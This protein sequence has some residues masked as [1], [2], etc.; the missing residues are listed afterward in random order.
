MSLVEAPTKERQQFGLLEDG[1]CVVDCGWLLVFF[2]VAG[3]V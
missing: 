2:F 3:V 1:C